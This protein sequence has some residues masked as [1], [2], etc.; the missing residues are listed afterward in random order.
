LVIAAAAVAVAA[1]VLVTGGSAR[2]ARAHTATS[3]NRPYN[4]AVTW[5]NGGS[6]GNT[7][8]GTGRFSA[9]LGGLAALVASAYQAATGVPLASIAK[10]GSYAIRITFLTRGQKG[11]LVA[12]FKAR[13]LGQSCA[14][15]APKTFYPVETGTIT[16][17][18]GTGSAARWRISLTFKLTSS[19]FGSAN[20]ERLAITGAAKAGLGSARRMTAAC[21]SVAKLLK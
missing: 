4:A 6:P 1:M 19:N 14:S 21:K 12:K 5:I 20:V 9:K 11:T 3:A 10:G 2:S 15:F 7:E 8:Q 17:I 13:G 18:G 16:T